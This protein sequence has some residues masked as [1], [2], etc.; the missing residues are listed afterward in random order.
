[1]PY[2]IEDSEEFWLSFRK[3]LSSVS[4]FGVSYLL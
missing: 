2:V 4:L 3:E 1:M